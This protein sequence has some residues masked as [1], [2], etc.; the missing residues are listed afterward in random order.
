VGWIHDD[1]TEFEEVFGVGH[2]IKIDTVQMAN[3]M[4]EALALAQEAGHPLEVQDL[5]RVIRTLRKL[6]KLDSV[7]RNPSQLDAIQQV[8]VSLRSVWLH[9]CLDQVLDEEHEVGT[10]EGQPRQT[11]P[12][13]RL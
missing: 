5:R 3:R 7:Q 6:E 2:R 13:R 11:S 9:F 10:P 1:W 12:K 4:I 8:Q